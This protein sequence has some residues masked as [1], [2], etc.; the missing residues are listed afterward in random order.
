M[1]K[2][3]LLHMVLYKWTTLAKE[4]RRTEGCLG[5]WNVFFSYSDSCGSL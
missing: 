4:K 2:T 5:L 1:H 3:I